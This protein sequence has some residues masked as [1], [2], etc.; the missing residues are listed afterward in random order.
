MPDQNAGGESSGETKSGV[1]DAALAHGP[2]WGGIAGA[3]IVGGAA[4]ILF[5]PSAVL[6]SIGGALG[7]GAGGLAGSWANRRLRQHLR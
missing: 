4:A 2:I 7:G 6:I 5:P 1:V 3:L